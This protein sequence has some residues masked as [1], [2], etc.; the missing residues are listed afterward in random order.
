MGTWGIKTFENDGTSDW[1]WELEETN[2]LSALAQALAPEETE[3]LEAPDGEII[4][5]AAEIIQGIK[6]GPREGLPENA[7]KW[8]SDHKHL[9]VSSLIKPAN[10][11]LDR[12]LNGK[13]ELRELWEEN[14]EDFGQWVADVTELR[15]MLID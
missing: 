10:E 4:I 14:A 6:N 12:V 2:D 8:I 11:L 13:S 15:N 1:L 3:Y 7:L 9:D 5:A